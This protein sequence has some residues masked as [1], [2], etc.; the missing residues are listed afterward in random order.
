MTENPKPLAHSWSKEALLAKAQLYCEQMHTCQRDEWNFGVWST[1]ALEFLSRAALANVSRTLLADPTHW[2]HLYFALGHL[3]HATKFVPKSVST[4]AVLERL[5]DILPSFNSSREGFAIAHIARR[6]EELHSGNTP[7]HGLPTSKW[8]PAFYD[9]CEV[10]LQSMDKDLEY[11][12]GAQEAEIARKLISAAQDQAARSVEATVNAHHAAFFANTV[13]EQQQLKA[14]AGVWATRHTGHR[15]K[16]PACESAALVGGEAIAAPTLY[17]DE[18]SYIIE[19]Q[20]YL[21]SRFECVACGLKIS[22]FSQLIAAGLG[23]AYTATFTY[24]PAEYYSELIAPQFE[25]DYNC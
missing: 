18:D 14:Q 12:L 17:L 5:K 9:V 8:L 22:D 2:H 23:D 11:L 4:K 10:L 1:L 25:E 24:E 7:F 20:Q 15:V 19:K 21:P 6:N 13:E 3:P 16:C